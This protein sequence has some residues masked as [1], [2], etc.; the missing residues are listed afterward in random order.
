[1]AGEFLQGATGQPAQPGQAGLAN[2]I[3]QLTG[4]LVGS[5]LQGAGS[6][7]PVNPQ[8][9]M[10]QPQIGNGAGNSSG[11]AQLPAT[12]PLLSPG[13]TYAPPGS[14]APLTESAPQSGTAQSLSYGAP[15]RRAVGWP[16]GSPPPRPSAAQPSATRPFAE[17]Q[18]R[19]PYA[20]GMA[21]PAVAALLT[22]P[23]VMETLAQVAPQITGQLAGILQQ[24]L[25]P[26][27]IN[28]I[29]A[30]LPTNKLISVIS[31]G[32]KEASRM[33][34]EARK[35]DIDH[36]E[37]ITQV[38]LQGDLAD[39]QFLL[40]HAQMN[41]SM[42]LELAGATTALTYQRIDSVRLDFSDR[43]SL[44]LGGRSRLLYRPDQDWA[45]PLTLQ[46]PRPIAQATLQ[47][48]VKHATTLEILIEAK[49]PVEQAAAG[50]L[51]VVPR[52]A[53]ERLTVLQPNEDYLVC[54]ALVWSGKPRG[55]RAKTQ[56]GTCMSQLITILGDYAFDRLEGEAPVVPLNDVEKYR[57]YWHKIWQTDL[58][59]HLRRVELDCRYYYALERDRSEN[60]RM[61]TLLKL[62]EK[63]GAEQTGQLKTGLILTPDRLNDLLT[64]ISSH[65]RLNDAELAA[66]KT[67]EFK[68][69]FTH[70][71]RATVKFKGKA[72]NTVA[73]WIYPE[74]KVQRLVLKQ[75]TK[76][77]DH[78][79]VLEMS[80]HPVHFPML[81]QVHFIGVST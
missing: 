24:A 4:A 23:Q 46:T 68:N 9:M 27:T 60:A 8:N 3:G 29:G 55:G 5:V 52:L 56:I 58:S 79:L 38:Q 25:S 75:A 59:K 67:V 42:S 35:Q 40:Q 22:N 70:A 62:D 72:G 77:N 19:S 66:L 33:Q 13:Q 34:M 39:N 50:P 31:D 44:M 48:L 10:L 47:L 41:Q 76:T 36:L 21:A 12:S 49:F 80:E 74:M 20:E 1:M 16:P 61:E 51:P 71:A 78:G 45:F 81:A 37:K 6:Q 2:Q 54:V 65:P 73:L 15:A 14:A 30:N 7:S 43:V 11:A 32:I 63:Q 57:A 18:S 17:A 28:A 26:E 64:Q 53:R 69:Q